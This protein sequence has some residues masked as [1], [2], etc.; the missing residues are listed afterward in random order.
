MI[1]H[2]AYLA[3]NADEIV[4]ERFLIQIEVSFNDLAERP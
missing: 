4:A 3:E 1:A 2:F